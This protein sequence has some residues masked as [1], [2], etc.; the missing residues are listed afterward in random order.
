MRSN[1]RSCLRTLY[2]KSSIH[3]VIR[4]SLILSDISVTALSISLSTE[5]ES[6]RSISGEANRNEIG[7]LS[8]EIISSISSEEAKVFPVSISLKYFG[9]QE[10]FYAS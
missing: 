2:K 3:R 1:P 8:T 6:F 7:I 9:L 5:T 4:M 10:I